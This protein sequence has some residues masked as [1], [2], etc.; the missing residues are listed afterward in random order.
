MGIEDPR[1]AARRE[2]YGIEDE[3]GASRDDVVQALMEVSAN[4][5]PA[6]RVAFRQLVAELR[7]WPYLEQEDSLRGTGPSPY[8]EITETGLSRSERKAQAQARKTPT[9]GVCGAPGAPA[10]KRG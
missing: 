4:Q 1:A 10:D 7:A 3:S 8:A 5:V 2:A 9:V 6:D